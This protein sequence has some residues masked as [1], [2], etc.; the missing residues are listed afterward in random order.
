MLVATVALVLAMLLFW[1]GFAQSHWVAP[2][3]LFT[4]SGPLVAALSWT[5]GTERILAHL[6]ANLALFYIAFALGR[7]LGDR[8]T[9]QAAKLSHHRPE[10]QRSIS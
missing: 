4:A 1:F 5:Y 9:A 3:A 10:T 8:N 2:A 7:W 6:I